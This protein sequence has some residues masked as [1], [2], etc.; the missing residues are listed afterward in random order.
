[1]HLSVEGKGS[2][3]ECDEP[4]LSRL[5][6]TII[7]ITST[8]RAGWHVFKYCFS[9]VQIGTQKRCDVEFYQL[10][11]SDHRI[12]LLLGAVNQNRQILGQNTKYD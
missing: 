2:W 12:V 8:C 7:R 9:P 11:F 6:K 4:R 3:A 5:P 1:M 10:P